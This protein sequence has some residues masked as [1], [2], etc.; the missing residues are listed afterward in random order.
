MFVVQQVS[1]HVYMSPIGVFGHVYL[2]GTGLVRCE[3]IAVDAVTLSKAETYRQTV[4][5]WTSNMITLAT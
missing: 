4:R 1:V 3:Y 5:A 2:F